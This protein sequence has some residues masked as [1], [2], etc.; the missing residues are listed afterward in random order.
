MNL[1]TLQ[2]VTLSLGHHP[3]L[4]EANLIIHSGERCGLIGRNGSGKS[5]LLKLID[6]RLEPD[7]GE[8]QKRV[9]LHVATVTQEP[10]LPSDIG[11]HDYLCANYLDTEDWQRP[12]LVEQHI[13]ALGLDRKS[14]RL[15]S[16]HVAISYAVFCLKKKKRT[17]PP[18]KGGSSGAGA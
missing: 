17:D 4:T 5:S 11:V 10:D 1:L 13:Q 2:D 16:S 3:L 15:N 18:V 9:G 8:V 7:S 6:G 12:A 14:T